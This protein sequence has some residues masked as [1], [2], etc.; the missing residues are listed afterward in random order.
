MD[1]INFTYKVVTCIFNSQIN[2]LLTSNSTFSHGVV[3]FYTQRDAKDNIP[4]KQQVKQVEREKFM[5]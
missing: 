4:V 5:R 3:A 2:A 1:Q